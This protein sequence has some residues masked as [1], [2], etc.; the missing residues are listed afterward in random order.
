[1]YKRTG[2]FAA[3]ALLASAALPAQAAVVNFN[4]NDTVEGG[5]PTGFPT[6]S[7]NDFGGTGTVELTI[8]ATG[9]SG[10]EFIS[11][12][13]FN[14][15]DAGNQ[16]LSFMQSGGTGPAPASIEQGSN[17][18]DSPGNQGMFDVQLIFSTS[19]SGGGINRFN[20]DEIVVLTIMG[21]G[22]TA[23]SFALISAPEGP[24]NGDN[25]ALARIQGIATGPGSASVADSDGPD[26]GPGPDPVPAPAALGLFGLG[27]V[28][29]GALRRRQS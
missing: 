11:N 15:A 29:I 5:A 17:T 7:F 20:A 26:D 9:L 12:V 4:L 16:V 21:M 13:F 8:D 25:F 28:A 3:I 1:M 19:N 24:N 10:G 14:F 2:R 18:Q 22:I 27:L 23:D 6:L